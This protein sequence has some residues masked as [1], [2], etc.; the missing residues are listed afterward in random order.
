MNNPLLKVSAR[1]DK[2]WTIFCKKVIDPDNGSG[3]ERGRS[4]ILDFHSPLRIRVGGGR[5]IKPK[6]R[7]LGGATICRPLWRG[8]GQDC[9]PP[10]TGGA[11]L[12]QDLSQQFS[13][14]AA[15]LG[16]EEGFNR[17]VF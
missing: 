8:G 7:R 16:G 4:S 12:E 5:V 14:F 1:A 10:L 17:L 15:A 2:R 13:M 11:N 3:G 6:N 9:P